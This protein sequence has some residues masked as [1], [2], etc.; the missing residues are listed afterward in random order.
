M[1]KIIA[2]VPR[3][4]G[5]FMIDTKLK[6]RAIGGVDGDRRDCTVGWP[7]SLASVARVGKVEAS[8]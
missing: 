8:L 1:Y 4:V 2:S 6:R 3:S 7:F 5:D